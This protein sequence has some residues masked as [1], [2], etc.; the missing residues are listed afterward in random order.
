[1]RE[2]VNYS[3]KQRGYGRQ[4]LY[5]DV[6]IDGEIIKDVYVKDVYPNVREHFDFVLDEDAGEHPDGIHF[7]D[8][9]GNGEYDI[10]FETTLE[11]VKYFVDVEELEIEI[12][13]E[14]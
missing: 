1:M 4:S 7:T 11:A 8:Q 9:N 3:T 6:F 12:E 5:A 14:D 13:I 2:I 10:T